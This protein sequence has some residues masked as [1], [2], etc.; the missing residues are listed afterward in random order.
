MFHPSMVDVNITD[1]YSE[2][3]WVHV[4]GGVRGPVYW[5][6][7]QYTLKIIIRTDKKNDPINQKP[8]KKQ[9]I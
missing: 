8:K 2:H 4:Q 3:V 1:M 6:T 7:D 9:F 5:T